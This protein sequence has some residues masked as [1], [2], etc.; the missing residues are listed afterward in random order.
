M[1]DV[2]L[3]YRC[4]AGMMAWQVTSRQE[5]TVITEKDKEARRV[6]PNNC[7]LINPGAMLTFDEEVKAEMPEYE[8]DLYDAFRSNNQPIFEDDR[9]SGSYV[10]WEIILFNL[11]IMTSFLAGYSPL[12][13]YS[14]VV[15]ANSA[16]LSTMVRTW[17]YQAWVIEIARPI[18][19]HRL[20]EAIHLH[21]HEENLVAEEE[22][23][24]LLVEIVRSPEL[25]RAITGSRVRGSAAPELDGL[26]ES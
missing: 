23:Y 12:L 4:E 3:L 16:L 26:T 6:H 19:I 10:M 1:H 11:Q 14:V 20:I 13:F 15:Y 21:K 5:P 9:Q 24:Y 22:T 18:V 2:K 25:V 7:S 17:S 8:H